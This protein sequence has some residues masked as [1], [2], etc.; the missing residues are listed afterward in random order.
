MNDVATARAL[1]AS[2]N[3]VEPQ[4]DGQITNADDLKSAA[5]EINYVP[6][7]S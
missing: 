2:I 1:R 5:A 6:E 4:C 3:Y 7:N